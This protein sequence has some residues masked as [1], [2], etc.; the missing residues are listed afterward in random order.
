[1]KESDS[2]NCGVEE[3]KELVPV[4][5][6]VVEKARHGIEKSLLEAFQNLEK[7]RTRIK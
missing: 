2:N 4:G 3:K 6:E 5:L 7:K 1:M